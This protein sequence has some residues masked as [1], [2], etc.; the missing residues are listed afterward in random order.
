MKNIRI[1]IYIGLFGILFSC[2]TPEKKEGIQTENKVVETVKTKTR[3]VPPDFN[4]DSAFVFVKAQADMGPR[5]PGSKAHDKCVAYFE[6]ELKRFG[7]EVSIQ[8]GSATSYDGL[9]WRIDNVIASFNANAQDRILLAAHYD[10]RPFSDNDPKPENQKKACPG[11]NDGASG[12]GVLMEI[13]R[14]LQ[15]K[16]PKVGV[17]IIMFDLEDYG[18]DNGDPETWCLGSQ[19]WAKSPHKSSYKA[20]YGIL[21][22]MVGATNAVFPREG[23]S[24][25]YAGDALNKVWGTAQRIGYGQ[26][27]IDD[28]TIEMT[29]DH[30][31]VNLFA[32]IPC[33]DILHYIPQKNKFFEHHHCVTDDISTID[34]TTLKAVGQTLLEVIYNED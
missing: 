27:F 22:D 28:P 1:T 10:S 21:L 2:S 25:K 9:S 20:K 3:V 13:A 18:D 33:I 15:T 23:V 7:A 14:I 24:V 12:T 31:F 26:F 4:S 16:N 11:V 5:V 30:L 34:K 17:D 32:K 8:G 19:A 29:D 6:K